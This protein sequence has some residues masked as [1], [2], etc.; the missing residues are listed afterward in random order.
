MNDDQMPTNNNDGKSK[1]FFVLLLLV[2]LLAFGAIGYA[3]MDGQ[4]FL[5]S[6]VVRFAQDDETGVRKNFIRSMKEQMD[7]VVNG[8]DEEEWGELLSDKMIAINYPNDWHVLNHPGNLP[9]SRKTV[10]SREPIVYEEN[11]YY[12]NDP[13]VIIEY[14][15]LVDELTLDQAL[16]DGLIEDRLDDLNDLTFTSYTNEEGILFD[17]YTGVAKEAADLDQ[18]IDLYTVLFEDASETL[19]HLIISST[20][21]DETIGSTSLKSIVDKIRFLPGTEQ[22]EIDRS[23]EE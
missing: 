4:K 15:A 20:Y 23:V 5:E 21:S 16:L 3:I 6:E 13:E 19:Y 17:H 2:I 11:G 7:E 22:V 14:Y 8:V 12:S 9:A 18:P 1:V 10:L